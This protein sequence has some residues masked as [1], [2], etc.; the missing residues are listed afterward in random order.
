M[1][2]NPS[3]PCSNCGYQVEQ[4]SPICGNCG[5]PQSGYQTGTGTTITAAGGNRRGCAIAILIVFVVIGTVIWG[6]TKKVGDFF[7]STQIDEITDALDDFES[8]INSPGGFELEKAE[9][10]YPGI[11]PLVLALNQGGLRCKE[12]DVQ[13][14]DEYVATGSC[15]VP[16]RGRPGEPPKTHVQINIFFAQTSLDAVKDQ[17]TDGAFTFVHDDNWFVITLDPVAKKIHKILGGQ[18][19]LR[20]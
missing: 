20:R 6:I 9:G 15:Q 10:P 3:L 7:Q 19:S 11:R 18:L 4:G 5:E 8:G 13:F 17:M 12:V 1:S 16:G 2:Q 14:A